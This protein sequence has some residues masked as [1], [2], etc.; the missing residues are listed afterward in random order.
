MFQI[1]PSGFINP[2]MIEVNMTYKSIDTT[3]IIMIEF[4]VS[5][6]T[7]TDSSHDQLEYYFSL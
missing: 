6:N 2:W 5:I 3:N 7:D 1:L 4:K